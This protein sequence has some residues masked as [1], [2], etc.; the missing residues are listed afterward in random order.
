MSKDDAISIMPNSNLTDKKDVLY[1]FFIIYKKLVNGI[2]LSA[3]LMKK[4][5]FK[6]K[7]KLEIVNRAEDYYKNDKEILKEQARDKYKN[8]SEEK[9]IKRENMEENDTI[10]CLKKRNKK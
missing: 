9:K 2:P 4:L 8:L 1:F 6:K 5:I 10:I 3:T 7:K